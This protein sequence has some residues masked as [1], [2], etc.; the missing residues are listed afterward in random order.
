MAKQVQPP[1]QGA[2]ADPGAGDFFGDPLPQEPIPD[3]RLGAQGSSDEPQRTEPIL[4]GELPPDDSGQTGVEPKNDPRRFQYHQS[5]ADRA[6]AFIKTIEPFLPVVRY[7]QENPQV[8]DLVERDLT[9]RN[10]QV[11]QVQNPPKPPERPKRPESYNREEAAT[12]GTPS[13]QY[14]QDLLE[15]NANFADYQVEKD[16]Y[17]DAL[18]QQEARELARQKQLEE[19]A[20]QQVEQIRGEVQQFYNAPPEVAED[21]IQWA[22]DPRYTRDQLWQIYQ[23]QRGNIQPPQRQ[24]QMTSPMGPAPVGAVPGGSGRLPVQQ[25]NISDQYGNDVI[26]AY[27]RLRGIPPPVRK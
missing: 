11:A 23:L 16:K 4:P 20:A 22:K 2:D 3:Q 12:P 15:Y 8:L 21:F 26:E 7:I 18:R 27:R 19:K 5:R 10:A 14:N 13:W 17:Q 9:T 6:E 24:P 25:Q 1:Q